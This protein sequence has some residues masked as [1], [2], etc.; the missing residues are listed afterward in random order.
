MAN[1]ALLFPG[2]GAQYPCMAQDFYNEFQ[3]V[4]ELFA[5]AS[6]NS[7]MDCA[8]LLFESSAEVL[9]D[10]E[11]TQ[12]AVTLANLASLT[13]LKELGLQTGNAV[14]AGFSLGEYAALAAAGTVSY[15]DCFKLTRARGRIMKR[16]GQEAAAGGAP[17]MAAVLGLEASKVEEVL[18]QSGRAD[19]FCANYNSP[20]QTV[21]SGMLAGIE[22]V[23]P[24]L[25]AAGAKR[26]MRLPVSGAFHTPLL[27][28]A[29][30]DFQEILG[31][32]R[33][34]DPAFPVYSNVT[35][36]R[37]ASGEQ[38]KRLLAKQIS[39]PVMWTAVESELAGALETGGVALECGPGT[40]L[41][42]F[43]KAA[44]A[45]PCMAAGK[46]EQILE[47]KAFLK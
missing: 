2:Q 22:A 44:N 12:V 8:K 26:V 25:S 47:L 41:S 34:N 33:F 19:I 29:G 16:R 31:Q 11:N 15:E 18:I 40:A 3:S 45:T 5:L 46:L 20:T 32:T 24:L 27:A 14:A 23:G 30:E 35:G 6:D 9:K 13:A 36:S 39:S 38:A 1:K 28:K 43:W 7:G 37:I 21:I 4:K 42:G 17:G 10:T